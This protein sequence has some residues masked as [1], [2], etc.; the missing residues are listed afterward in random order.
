[1]K[2]IG[3]SLTVLKAKF[4]IEELA[5]GELLFAASST[6]EIK[7]KSPCMGGDVDVGIQGINFQHMDFGEH[8]RLL[9]SLNFLSNPM[10]QECSY[11]HFIYKE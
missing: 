9:F 3:S 4:S 11:P 7:N 6:A 1:M 2:K 10:K 5:F 8:I